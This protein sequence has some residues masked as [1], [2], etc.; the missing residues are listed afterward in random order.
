MCFWAEG[1]TKVQSE[2]V[3]L[4]NAV[5]TPLKNLLLEC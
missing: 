1:A 3:S 5:N 2:E 4:G